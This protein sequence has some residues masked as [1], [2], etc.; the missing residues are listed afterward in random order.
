[1]K[2]TVKFEKNPVKVSLFSRGCGIISLYAPLGCHR[3]REK[4][5]IIMGPGISAKY[6]KRVLAV[7]AVIAIVIIIVAV[8]K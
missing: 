1:M 8:V 4:E 6:A 7:L 2:I 5:E 3:N